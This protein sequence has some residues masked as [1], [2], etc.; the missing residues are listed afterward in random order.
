MNQ[1]AKDHNEELSQLVTMTAQT[2]L[3][4]LDKT[5]FSIEYAST[6]YSAA[7]ARTSYIGRYLTLTIHNIGTTISEEYRV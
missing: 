6:S 3:V 4:A 7:A 2:N 5:L 1:A